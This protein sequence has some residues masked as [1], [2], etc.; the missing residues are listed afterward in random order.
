MNKK[1]ILID[2][3][4]LMFRA[5]YGTINQVAFFEKNN[6]FPTNAI[7]TMMLIIFKILENN[8]YD[9]A[10]IAFDHKDK[11]FRKEEFTEYKGKRKSTPE[12]LVKQIPIIQEI[13]P[14]FGLNTFCISGIE[15][16]DVIGSAST[17]LSNHNIFCEIYSSDNDLLQLV[18]ENVNVIQFKKGI[19]EYITY[20]SENFESMSEGLKPKQII[21]YKGLC[22]DSSDNIPGIK[23]IGHK[24]A[25]ELL[26]QFNN[27]ENIIN[28][29]DF[30]KSK[31]VKEKIVSG[32]EM[33]IKCKKLATILTD[34]FT[35]SKIDE[36]E[37]KK[38]DLPKIND[39]IKKYN[40]SGFNKYIKGE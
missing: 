14:L 10:V 28:N 35:N 5:Y 24:T 13:M 15:A 4:S 11:N 7:K 31:S 25:I 19:T 20:T 30:I 22:G 38:L 40:F 18:N 26:K 1:A 23:G 39:V 21:D 37:T 33:G 8:K 27:L 29:A 12:L 16:D 17:L 34:Y 2:G 6:I 32:K 9:Y 36:F 3:N